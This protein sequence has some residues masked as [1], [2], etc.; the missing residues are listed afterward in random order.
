VEDFI[1]TIPSWVL[2]IGGSAMA[3]AK[4][5]LNFIEFLGEENSKYSKPV[6]G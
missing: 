1:G 2:N 5:R 4:Q 6:N 3:E